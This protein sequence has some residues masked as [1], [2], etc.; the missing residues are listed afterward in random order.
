MKTVTS[1]ES[2]GHK[3]LRRRK[4]GRWLRQKTENGAQS[5]R[6]Q[7]QEESANSGSAETQDQSALPSV[8]TPESI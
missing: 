5:T 1:A 3:T 8:G 4:E 2:D 6:S 7:K